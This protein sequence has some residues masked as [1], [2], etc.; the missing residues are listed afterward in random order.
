MQIDRKRF[1]EEGY[2]IVREAI[3]PDELESVRAAYET[4]VERQ[5]K[6]WAEDRGPNDP[7]GGV[8]ETSAQPRLNIGGMAEHL[9]SE[10]I[11][12][13]ETWLYDNIQGV[14]SAL[15]DVPD[16]GVTEMMLMCS[17]VRD[18]GTGGHRGWHRDLYPPYCAPL[19]G[20]LDDI[21]ENGPRYIQWNIPLYDDNVLWVVPGSHIR[22][23][24]PE[25]D[26]QL[27]ENDHVPVPGGVQTH[28]KA[29]DGVVYILP[30]LHWG[31]NYSARL[32]RTVH[33]GFS[34][35]NQYRDRRFFDLLSLEARAQFDGWT[36]RSEDMKDH[37]EAALRA[38]LSGDA[39]AYHAA[40][41]RLHPGRGPKGKALTTVYLS[42][43]AKRINDLKQ[44]DFDS[45]AAQDKAWAVQ[46]HPITLQWGAD[47]ADRFSAGEAAQIWDRF[48]Q[49]DA[50]IRSE[51]QQFSPSF[52][53]EKSY[54]N[55]I[56][57]P[58]EDVLY[59]FLSID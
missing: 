28:L 7:P 35:Y 23:N 34:I 50:L 20:Y 8:W 27:L 14:S 49:V 10:T 18:H 54:Y 3:P 9:D 44:P 39:P 16:A 4:M 25:E 24:T 58:D 15:L 43:T 56:D 33:G 37:T 48:K 2:L 55:F 41:D 21:R 6:I 17:P 51:T 59:D 38:A 52:Q 11:K 53:G 26:A 45:L 13:V 40:L 29:G 46:N 22:V 1:L 32:R 31:S 42:K 19:K 30:I 47:F 36:Q 12:T 57:M 5:K